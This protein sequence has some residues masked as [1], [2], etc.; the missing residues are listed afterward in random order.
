MTCGYGSAGKSAKADERGQY[1]IEFEPKDGLSYA[2]TA[3]YPKYFEGTRNERVS[4]NKKNKD[5]N[6][7]LRPE[8]YLKLILKMLILLMTVIIIQGITPIFMEIV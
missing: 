7:N 2:V 1:K 8:A 5:V 6:L 3:E 4:P